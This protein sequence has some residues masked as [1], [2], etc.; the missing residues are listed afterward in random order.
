MHEE[1]IPRTYKK[2]TS[3]QLQHILYLVLVSVVE[4]TKY[5]SYIYAVHAMPQQTH[6]FKILLAAKATLCLPIISRKSIQSIILDS[7]QFAHV[8]PMQH[9]CVD[10]PRLM[11][12]FIHL[13]QDFWQRSNLLVSTLFEVV[14]H[15][16]ATDLAK[17]LVQNVR[18]EFVF[19]NV[20]LVSG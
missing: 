15:A 1:C 7:L 4:D 5:T 13:S 17:R 11:P 9:P 12:C 10:T 14:R 18:A 20:G 8:H 3:T 16:D 6:M 19:S 2:A